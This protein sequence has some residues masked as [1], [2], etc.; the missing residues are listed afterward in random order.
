MFITAGSG[1]NIVETVRCQPYAYLIRLESAPQNIEPKVSI[2]VIACC[3]RDLC[4]RRVDLNGKG[5]VQSWPGTN[6]PCHVVADGKVSLNERLCIGVKRVDCLTDRSE[7]ACLTQADA[8]HFAW[9]QAVFSN[10]DQMPGATLGIITTHC[11]QDYLLF[12][13]KGAMNRYIHQVHPREA[14]RR[15][16]SAIHFDYYA[17]HYHLGL[18]KR[19]LNRNA[20]LNSRDTSSVSLFLSI[21]GRHI[22]PTPRIMQSVRQDCSPAHLQQLHV[23]QNR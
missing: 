8:D 3:V 6:V 12:S 15:D 7:V 5:F 17:R 19:A 16:F 20:R 1:E 13:I 18:E 10:P 14:D 21:A 4:R 11:T 23:S 2:E 9:Q 22:G